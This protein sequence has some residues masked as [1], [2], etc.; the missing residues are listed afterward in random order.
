V[1]DGLFEIAKADGV[2]HPAESQFLERVAERRPACAT[3]LARITGA[4][5]RTRFGAFPLTP[6]EISDVERS[7][8]DLEHTGAT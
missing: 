8:V 6:S 1:L 5:E 3:P 2:L 7:L 4:Y